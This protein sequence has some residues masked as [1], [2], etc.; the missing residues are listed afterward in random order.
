MID[1]SSGS[2]VVVGK[3]FLSTYIYPMHFINEFIASG[4]AQFSLKVR[5]AAISRMTLSRPIKFIELQ[6]RP[7]MTSST[8]T[9]T[10]DEEKDLHLFQESEKP[11]EKP[12]DLDEITLNSPK[13]STN[14]R[15]KEE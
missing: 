15:V 12:G 8:S 6:Y 5:N 14:G 2:S 1:A 7:Y 4:D 3:P 10:I 11:K 9:Q 13:R